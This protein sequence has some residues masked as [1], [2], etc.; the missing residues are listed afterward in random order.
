[1]AAIFVKKGVKY[2][3]CCCFREGR[4]RKKERERVCM[5]ALLYVC[6]CGGGGCRYLCRV[7][8]MRQS[9]R[10]IHQCL[11]NMPEGEIK[12]DDNKISPPRRAEMKV[13]KPCGGTRLINFSFVIFGVLFLVCEHYT[14]E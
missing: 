4:E 9:L 6:L 13:S 14:C 11:N 8:E 12:V 5:V 2:M 1:M 3:Y 10:I 7:E